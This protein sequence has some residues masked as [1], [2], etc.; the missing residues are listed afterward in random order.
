MFIHSTSGLVTEQDTSVTLPDDHTPSNDHAPSDNHTT[1]GANA[2]PDSTMIATE[3]PPQGE[4]PIE[5]SLSTT[6]RSEAM[7]MTCETTVKYDEE[8]YVE[9][10]S[11]L[12]LVLGLLSLCGAG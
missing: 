8:P 11:T 6:T 12:V 10:V 9:Q 7:E 5:P 4:E 3:T 1:T 2:A